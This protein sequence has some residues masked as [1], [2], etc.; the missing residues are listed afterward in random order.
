MPRA[1]DRFASRLTMQN[2]V[3]DRLGGCFHEIM[4]E[5]PPVRTKIIARFADWLAERAA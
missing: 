4:N 2:K 1:T 5:G 3:V